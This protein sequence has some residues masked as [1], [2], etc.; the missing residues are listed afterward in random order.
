MKPDNRSERLKNLSP[1]KRTLLLKALRK[2]A[3]Q[4]EESKRI[5]RRLQQDY[6]P[7]SFA[8]QRL[9]FLD[10]LSPQNYAYNLPAAVRLKGQLN[11]PALQQTFNE[12]LRRHEV[13]RTAFAEVNGQPAQVISPDIKF[14][15][16]VINLQNLPESQQK[17]EVEKQAVEEAQRP[18][19]LTQ[20]PLL[21]ATL[22]QLNDAE[23]V[24]LLTMHHIISDGWSMGVLVREVGALYEA[25]STSKSSPLPEL[26]VQYGDFSSWQRQ[27]L[28]GEKLEKQLAY[29]KQQLNGVLDVMPTDRQRSSAQNFRGAE[30]SFVISASLTESLKTLIQQQEVTLFMILLAVF[31]AL[32]YCHTKQENLAIGSPIANRSRVELEGLIGFFVNTLVLKIDIAGNPT[33]RELLSRVR[34]TT[35]QAYAH[36]DVPFEKLVEELQPERNLSYNP[37]F[38][39]WFVL[40]NAPMPP[41]ELAGLTLSVLEFGAGTSR[42]DFSLTCWEITEGIQ[43]LFE[44]K[45]DL[46]EAASIERMVRSFKTIV[47]Q[48][49]D[50]PNIRINDLAETVAE[51]E[52]QH[53]KNKEKQLQASNIQKLK[54]AKRKATKK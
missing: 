26:P 50:Q 10:K 31:K 48:I 24:L 2:N 32:L 20:A 5:Q 12:I 7:L 40:Q 1:D 29:W 51:A 34:E 23:Y 39:V 45:T 52:K 3:V 47:H 9:W 16:A 14:N 37:L 41:L 54:I 8:Q 30:Q 43:G 19:D 11:L 38:Q 21:R 33:F 35:L 53:Q 27:S 17:I 28:Q 15:V 46:F 42:H 36:P 18:F 49:V 4:T 6:A 25:F 44:Y 22:L 13:L